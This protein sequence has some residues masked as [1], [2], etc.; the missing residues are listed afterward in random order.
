MAAAHQRV[1]HGGADV[2]SC[3]REEDPHEG[4]IS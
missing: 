3:A 2:T 1:E 4:R